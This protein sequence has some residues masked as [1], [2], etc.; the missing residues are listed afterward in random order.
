MAST[1]SK[2]HTIY[3]YLYMKISVVIGAVVVA[4]LG[5]GYLATSQSEPTPETTP[6]AT[7]GTETTNETAASETDDM[8]DVET[9]VD[10][11]VRSEPA[12]E[13]SSEQSAQAAGTYTTYS[14]SALA[15]ST[16]E[17]NVIFFHAGW[18]PSCRAL[19]KNITA[20]QDSIPPGVAIFKADYDAETALKQQY[21]VVRQHSVVVV[22][23]DGS[24]QRGVSHP[25]TLEQLV[26]GL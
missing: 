17:S 21:G 20:Q 3:T 23:A 19:D 4:I 12:P 14:A 1:H 11:S 6:A 8:L 9:S 10:S 7:A 22:S 18:C 5:I 16:A 13:A 26:A 15:A 25:A 24:L 2:E